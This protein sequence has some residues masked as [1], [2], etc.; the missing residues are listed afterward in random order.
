MPIN[1]P[2]IYSRAHLWPILYIAGMLGLWGENCQNMTQL[3]RSTG[4]M[5]SVQSLWARRWITVYLYTFRHPTSPSE[6]ATAW[7]L[8]V[9]KETPQEEV[10]SLVQADRYTS[11]S[12]LLLPI[13]S[14][15]ALP[16]SQSNYTYTYVRR[17][18]TPTP[19]AQAH[20]ASSWD[21]ELR[22]SYHS[23]LRD[24]YHKEL[25]D[26]YQA[27]TIQWYQWRLSPDSQW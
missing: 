6:S 19:W 14:H 13:Y 27:P 20:G 22:D 17:S 12:I 23:D 2:N 16:S 10:C 7:A 1:E 24:S 25:R 21:N 8:Y 9:H 26:S 11:R 5:C 18:N 4:G 15:S 3:Y